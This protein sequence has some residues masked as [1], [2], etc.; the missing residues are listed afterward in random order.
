MKAQSRSCLQPKFDWG[1]LRI[2]LYFYKEYVLSDRRYKLI[3][4]GLPGKAS[5]KLDDLLDGQVV[6]WD[7]ASSRWIPTTASS[8]GGVWGA[9]TGTL[10][11]Q[12]DLQAALDGKEPTNTKPS[13]GAQFSGGYT[14]VRVDGVMEIGRYVDWHSTDADVT[15]HTYRM[16]NTADG[17]MTFSGNLTAGIVSAT[18][19]T[20]TQWN[21]AYGWGDHAAAGYVPD[22]AL[23]SGDADT[24][25]ASQHT[26][27]NNTA[28]NMP[29]AGSYWTLVV[30]G[31]GT[32]I[33]SQLATSFSTGEMYSR[34]FNSAWSSWERVWRSGDFTQP[35]QLTGGTVTGNIVLAN[36]ATD[37]PGFSVV[38]S[39]NNTSGYMDMGGEAIRWVTGYRGAAGVVSM[40]L[41]AYGSN[42]SVA[43]GVTAGGVVTAT[44][45]T[46]TQ[47]NT[48]YGWGDHSGTYLPLTGG[49]LTGDLTVTGTISEGG[50]LLT[51]KYAQLGAA[52]DYSN[53]SGIQRFNT[54]AFALIENT[55]SISHGLEVT[56]QAGA[57]AFMQFH[58]SGDYAIKFGLRGSTNKL[59][60]GGWSM[61]ANAYAIY[62]EGNKPA[63]D[64]LT[65]TAV[66]AADATKLGGVLPAV[67][68][69]V[70][71]I[72]KRGTSG[73]VY[74]RLFRST[75]AD[76]AAVTAGAAIMMRVNNS[77]DSYL[78]PITQAGFLAE[79]TAGVYEPITQNPSSGD[80]WSGGYSKVNTDGTHEIGKY[81]D[82]HDTDAGV[83]DNTYRMTNTADDE[84]TFSGSLT[85][86]GILK[87]SGTAATWSSGTGTPE[88]VVTAPVGSMFTRTD[89]GTGT[90]LYVKETGTGN[91]G[92]VA[93]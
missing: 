21:T 51:A 45:G 23:F 22:T 75:F 68:D 70:S 80:W 32:N 53:T 49:T 77:T 76:T 30:S 71:T 54:Q 59:T 19:G 90:T 84:M 26:T 64:D 47:W 74:A 33:I 72:V 31:N 82:W 63:L 92:W 52:N 78:R 56:A 11:A 9:I 29:Y 61:G 88:A 87:V 86:N 4:S 91:T 15:D 73:D 41:S 1:G 40:Q 79:V 18:G 10:S 14:P 7:L 37:T 60:V 5:F 13:S 50:S 3:G 83:T 25:K 55:S 39:V 38:D 58:I 6:S 43:G 65:G 89:G 46:S 66:L 93:K 81:L 69:V 34:S 62:H 35:L 42:L 36:G 85:V 17:E 57:D 2:P 48:A 67:G 16:D 24:L 44:G 27:I 28:T 12:T 8:G 20:S